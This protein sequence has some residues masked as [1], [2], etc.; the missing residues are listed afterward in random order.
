[1]KKH[2]SIFVLFILNIGCNHGKWLPNGAYRPKHPHFEIL[3]EK[4]TPNSLIDT[5]FLYIS[6]LKYSDKGIDH[7]MYDCVGFYGDGRMIGFTL[8]DSELEKITQANSWETAYC[9]GHYTTEGNHIKYEY[10]VGGDVGI[11]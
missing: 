11:S 6:L 4:F 9:V 2:L 5:N 8:D 1:M 10:F 7:T 3:K